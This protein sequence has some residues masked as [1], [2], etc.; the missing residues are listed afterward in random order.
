MIGARKLFA[1]SLNFLLKNPL[2]LFYN[3]LYFL[4]VILAFF[5]MF[6]VALSVGALSLVTFDF[7]HIL[8]TVSSIIFGSLF[9]LIVPLVIA[10]PFTV[11]SLGFTIYI[12]MRMRSSHISMLNSLNRAWE[13]CKNVWWVVP[14][15]ILYI[16]SGVVWLGV[17]TTFLLFYTHQFLLDGETSFMNMLAESWKLLK[18]TFW[19]YIRLIIINI[20]F[21]G[22]IFSSAIICFILSLIPFISF[23]FV[24]LGFFLSIIALLFCVINFIILKIGINKLYLEAQ[25]QN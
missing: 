22:T 9:A 5:G 23:I 11:V 18:K 13:I 25:Q 4:P 17:F 16:F 6:I 1:F 3:L 19:V 2:L 8:N 24:F 12:Q 21:T 7:L 10:L 20:I 14:L 15:H